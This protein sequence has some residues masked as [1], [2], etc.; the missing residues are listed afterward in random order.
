M[1]PEKLV[2]W[3]DSSSGQEM[4]RVDVLRKNGEGAY[5]FVRDSENVDFPIDVRNFGPFEEDL[6]IQSLKEV[7]PGA[8][9][10]LKF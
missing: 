2:I 5:E 4:W 6:L 9:I 10:S 8:D 3:P 7:F 1:T